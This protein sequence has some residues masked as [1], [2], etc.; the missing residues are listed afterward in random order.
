MVSWGRDGESPGRDGCAGGPP[1]GVIFR[2]PGLGTGIAIP[3]PRPR[4]FAADN[5]P[6]FIVKSILKSLALV[7][8]LASMTMAASTSF[9][10]TSASI[11]KVSVLETV[12]NSNGSIGSAPTI[13]GVEFANQDIYYLELKNDAGSNAMVDLLGKAKAASRPVQL[14]INNDLKITVTAPNA[15][16]A[17][18]PQ[19][20]GV[21]MN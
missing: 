18:R 9:W 7:G 16:T 4:I 10:T 20:M 11:V 1:K 21:S 12:S 5:Y 3:Y 6:E 15:Q 14:F 8:A 19:I 17:T 2:G 13:V